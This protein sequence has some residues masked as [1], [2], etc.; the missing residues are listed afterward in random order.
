MLGL[1]GS[2]YTTK[3]STM[4]I[5]AHIICSEKILLRNQKKYER[6][7]GFVKRMKFSTISI[8]PSGKSFSNGAKTMS[9]A[10]YDLKA[11]CVF[12]E[13]YGYRNISVVDIKILNIVSSFKLDFAV[14]LLNVYDILKHDH[15]VSYE[16]ELS[17]GLHF[18]HKKINFILHSSGKG[19]ITNVK[20]FDDL[21]DAIT[22]FIM[23]LR[24]K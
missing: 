21:T 24:N 14:N 20:T 22:L 19:I 11:F 7:S 9:H 17:S 8:Y 5:Q 1:S 2:H 6:F 12:L 18:V 13:E 10:E 23:S 16:P 3:T 15:I 4:M